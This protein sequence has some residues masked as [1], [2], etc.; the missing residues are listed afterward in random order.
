VAAVVLGL[1]ASVSWGL[2]DFIGGLKSRTVDLLAVL[3]VSQG[4]ALV[5]LAVA[6]AA[7]GKEP[8]PAS[9]LA[10]AGAAGAAGV[11]GLAALYR[12]LAVGA[13][14]VVAPIAALGAALPVTV[15]IATGD[16][17]GGVQV[18]GIVLALAGVSL[19]AREEPREGGGARLAVGVGLA[20]AA[21]T[22]IGLFLVGMD[23]ASD[24]GVLWALF[25]ARVVSV[26]ALVIAALFARPDLPAARPH[27]AAIGAI[28]VLD[29]S[30]NGLFA[31]AATEGLVSV[32]SVCSSLYP[33]VTIALAR[34]VLSERVRPSQ[35]AGVVLV[36]AGVVGIAAG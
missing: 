5:L 10:A 29:L 32:A 24:D 27:L 13:M 16:R 3:V 15:G 35:Q 11:A 25:F 14:A 8:P 12:G 36:M 31:L 6:V 33:V 19:A 7:S 1:A 4:L 18:I 34:S 28:G 23:A 26:A 17:P 21:A 2:A 30:A 20:A 22:G 9:A